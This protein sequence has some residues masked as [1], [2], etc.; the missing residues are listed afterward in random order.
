MRSWLL[1]CLAL[2]SASNYG[3]DDVHEE[4]TDDDPWTPC[5]MNGV[6]GFC[7]LSCTA[8][9]SFAPERMDCEQLDYDKLL[10]RSHSRG[11]ETFTEWSQ[12]SFSKV[13]SG[14]FDTDDPD[15]A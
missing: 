5:T 10:A 2:A 8:S 3:W 14:D 7:R 12:D 13:H 11:M 4:G 9:W 6:R 1:A 15:V